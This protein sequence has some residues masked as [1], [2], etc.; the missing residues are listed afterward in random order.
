MQINK[1]KSL[2]MYLSDGYHN[3]NYHLQTA[4]KAM[5]QNKIKETEHEH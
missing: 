3:A 4:V 2:C 1:P 5:A